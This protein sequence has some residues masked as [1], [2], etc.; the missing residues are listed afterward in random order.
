RAR[1]LRDHRADARPRGAP[2]RGRRGHRAHAAEAVR[3]RGARRRDPLAHR[4]AGGRMIPPL[5]GLPREQP[6][7]LVLLADPDTEVAELLAFAFKS[8]HFRVTLAHDGEEALR[9]AQSERPDLVIADVRLPAR[10]G[11]EICGILRRDTEHGDVP[12]VLLS[13]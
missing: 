9:R 12:V 11:L 7:P 2:A 8:N 10:S 3:E 4:A 6:A 5:P 13:P 1:A